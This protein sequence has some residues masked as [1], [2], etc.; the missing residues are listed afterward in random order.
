MK[1]D[2]ATT[3]ISSSQFYGKDEGPEDNDYDS[4]FKKKLS[5]F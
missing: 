1:F 3:S 5:N 4:S 2:K